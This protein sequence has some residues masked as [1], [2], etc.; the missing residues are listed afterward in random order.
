MTMVPDP[1]NPMRW[2]QHCKDCGQPLIIT[3]MNGSPQWG[4]QGTYVC[5]EC[6]RAKQVAERLLRGP[7]Y[8]VDDE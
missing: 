4:V 8:D 3:F 2:N 1:W 7:A 5:R 6:D